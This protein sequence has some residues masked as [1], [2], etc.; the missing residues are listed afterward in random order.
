MG[1]DVGSEVS[2]ITSPD[3]N[4]AAASAIAPFS[5]IRQGHDTNRKTWPA[6]WFGAISSPRVGIY[7]LT[8]AE[9]G[10]SSVQQL[11][12]LVYAMAPLPGHWWRNCTLWAALASWSFTS[13]FKSPLQFWG[14]TLHPHCWSFLRKSKWP[15]GAL[16][17]HIAVRSTVMECILLGVITGCFAWVLPLLWMSSPVSYL[18]YLAAQQVWERAGCS[19]WSKVSQEYLPTVY[20][21]SQA[22]PHGGMF[23]TVPKDS[24]M[25]KVNCV[26]AVAFICLSAA[27]FN[28]KPI[29]LQTLSPIPGTIKVVWESLN[30]KDTSLSGWQFSIPGLR[31]IFLALIQSM[32][33]SSASP[34]FSFL[35]PLTTTHTIFLLGPSG[36][37]LP[38]V[39]SFMFPLIRW[40]RFSKDLCK[41]FVNA[42]H[43]TLK[44]KITSFMAVGKYALSQS[45]VSTTFF[46]APL[47][48]SKTHVDLLFLKTLVLADSNCISSLATHELC[49][50]LPIFSP[51]SKLN[52]ANK[53]CC[54]SGCL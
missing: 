12:S 3:Y 20:L 9:D 27:C 15:F 10:F 40:G 17:R 37:S 4:A 45:P 44:R 41:S 13:T 8:Y 53:N 47:Q 5:W 33:I 2:W 51:I 23:S 29:S 28:P 24:T 34:F 26:V 38:C 32:Q 36:L 50:S 48:T 1:R 22:S 39:L 19:L 49:V 31:P 14:P 7:A 42:Y 25:D 46:H 18:P 16:W 21:A 35:L 30:H 52:E 11:I 6:Q 54:W 43:I